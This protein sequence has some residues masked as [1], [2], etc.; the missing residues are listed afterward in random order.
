MK[1][2]F[3]RMWRKFKEGAETTEIPDGVATTL[4]RVGTAA[5][6]EDEKHVNVSIE[7][8]DES[9]QADSGDGAD[10]GTGDIGRS[11]EAAVPGGVG[12]KPRRIVNKPD[13][14][15]A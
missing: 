12:H 11:E 3:R 14:G 15:S 7:V 6:V 4:I 1:I 8:H 5:L 2:R 10:I 9:Q 13:S